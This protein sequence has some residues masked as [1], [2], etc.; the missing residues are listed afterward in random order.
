[1]SKRRPRSSPKSAVEGCMPASPASSCVG[2]HPASGGGA[3]IIPTALGIC[4][5]LGA[6]AVV[7]GVTLNGHAKYVR[8]NSQP[9]CAM[10]WVDIL[11]A[12]ADAAICCPASVASSLDQT[13]GPAETM[14]ADSASSLCRA[15][16]RS[17]ERVL[18]SFAGAW[19]LPLAPWALGAADEGLHRR[20]S[21]GVSG[22][23]VR[24]LL[25]V[26]LMFVRTLLMYKAKNAVEDWVQGDE[27]TNCAYAA[28]R[29]GGM[30]KENWNM[31]DHVVLLML[32]H[33]AVCGSELSAAV[34]RAKERQ[35]NP[36]L[37]AELDVS[38][39]EKESVKA[40][41]QGQGQIQGQ[42]QGQGQGQG[43]G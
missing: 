26:A 35:E 16:S 15:A 29:R 2:A 38:A 17:T 22:P 25:Y 4:L 5:A 31:A 8:I 6:A 10:S 14:R 1:M 42:I 24:L 39:A 33:I 34:A 40:Q 30:C 32:H 19:V 7:F 3:T 11:H 21:P 28:L 36:T 13:G 27:G 12:D 37:V 41:G 20:R 43:Q 18:T 9:G 23:A